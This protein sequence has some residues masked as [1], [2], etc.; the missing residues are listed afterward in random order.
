[1]FN[2]SMLQEFSEVRVTA[3]FTECASRNTKTDFA[4][5]WRST[6]VFRKEVTE[7][8]NESCEGRCAGRS[9]PV[10]WP[11]LSLDLNSLDFFL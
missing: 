2:S 10:A 8:V 9:G 6:S 11:A 1:M 5:T 7:F 4:A 3:A